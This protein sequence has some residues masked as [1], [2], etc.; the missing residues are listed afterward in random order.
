[1][2]H[3]PNVVLQTPRVRAY[4]WIILLTI[5]ALTTVYMVETLTT[6]QS[7]AGAAPMLAPTLSH[8]GGYYDRDIRLT[9]NGPD[10]DSAVI[11]TL[12]GS[13]PTHTVGTTYTHPIHL[14]AAAPAV[15]VIRARAVLPDGKLGPVASASYF[16]GVS[17]TLPMISLIMDPS[18]LWDPQR[19]IYVNYD[20]RGDA[21]ERPADITYVDRDRRSGFHIPAG[22]R[23]HG[24]GSRDYDK[25]ALRLYFRQ[26]YGASRL[27]YP[28]FA[29]SRVARS[30]VHSFKRLVLHNGGQDCPN[31][32]R[33][34]LGNWTLMRNQL[35]DSLAI[36]LGGYATRAQPVLMF[37]NGESWGI[38]HIRERPDRYFL[39]DHYNIESADLLNAPGILGEQS[40]VLGDNEHWEHLLEFVETHD[41]VDPDNYAYIQSQMNVANFIDYSIL[42]IYVANT[43]WPHHNVRQFRPRV[44]GGRWHWLFWDTDNGLGA[45]PSTPYSRVDTNLIQHVLTY[46]HPVTGGRDLLL[47]RKLLHAPTFLDRFLSRTADLLNTT[48]APAS[49]IARIDALAAELQPDIAYETI[50]WPRPVNWESNVEELRD[51]AR[52]RPDF[53]RQHIVEGLNLNGTAQ[54]TFDPPVDSSGYVAVHGSL[55]PD[56]PWQGTYFQGV[57]VQVTAVPMPG[58]RFA[59]WEPPDLPQTP[60]ITLVV[61]ISQTITPRFERASENA[62]RPGD[63]IFAGYHIDETTHIAGNWFELQVMRPGGVDLRGWRV[64]D[65]DT[66]TATDE[67]SLIFAADPAFAHVPQGTII[68]VIVP[69]PVERRDEQGMQDDLNAWDRRMVLYAPN[70]NMDGESDP[71][72]NLGPNDALVLLAPGSTSAYDDDQ[73]I[74]FASTNT[75]V[76]PASFGVLADGVL[77]TE[78]D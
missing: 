18:D 34:D 53:V 52:R 78:P 59:G 7:S 45:Y 77:P 1:V 21:W 35:V 42:Q 58:Y 27:E 65:N 20:E 15:A 75:S 28:L 2:R 55:L 4:P 41:L 57:P 48:L 66:K 8:P 51:F 44:Q 76:T 56:L 46:N 19:G 74:A 49:V 40:V 63:V 72:F 68:R 23:I 73:G 70:P 60:V 33:G 3:T 29:D 11:F 17:A 24:G 71:G 30:N 16:V 6:R 32:H 67:G 22:I 50:R 12:D 5:V 39:N 25:K 36:Q 38:Y 9:I 13:V 10:P 26:E 64:T 61:S 47:L 37:I 54:L 14:S 31:H 69:A 62:S 43:D